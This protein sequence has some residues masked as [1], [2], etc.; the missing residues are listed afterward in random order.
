MHLCCTETNFHCT[1]SIWGEEPEGWRAA[2]AAAET[3]NGL[4]DGRSQA[5]GQGELGI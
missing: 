2:A 3:A 5:L 1:L 4:T